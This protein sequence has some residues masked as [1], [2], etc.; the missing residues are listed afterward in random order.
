M[1]SRNRSKPVGY[2]KQR[3]RVTGELRLNRRSLALLFDTMKELSRHIFTE[4]LIRSMREAIAQ[5]GQR[6]ITAKPYR[7]QTTINGLLRI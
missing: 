4:P 2:S 1:Y 5:F 3:R 7:L 6:R